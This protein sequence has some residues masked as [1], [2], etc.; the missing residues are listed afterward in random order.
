MG[1]NEFFNA[2]RSQIL[3][4][5]PLPKVT[6]V[7]STVIQ[8]ER[9]YE[10]TAT[11]SDS[12]AFVNL[13]E[14]R[15]YAGRGKSAWGSK[16]CCYCDK[17]GHTV[18]TCYM[19]HGLPPWLKDKSYSSKANKIVAEEDN[20][21]FDDLNDK[22][23]AAEK[24][25]I[26]K[27][28]NEE[29]RTL[30]TLLQKSGFQKKESQLDHNVNQVCSSS[31]IHTG[32]NSYVFSSSINHKVEWIFDCG[33]TDHICSC[34]NEFDSFNRINP[35]SVRLPNGSTLLT[36]LSGDVRISNSLLLKDVLYIPNFSCNLISI[37]K[38]NKAKIT[39]TFAD[40]GCSI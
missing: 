11:S 13:A 39:C 10:V 37:S 19:K 20:D 38:L 18:E 2:V 30:L 8:H 31:A 1:F 29:C 23:V 35:I 34:L 27:L 25:S 6:R 7:F 28:S 32:G 33:A 3:L 14:G 21:R 26:P 22:P 17:T 16:Q 40:E 24:H 4:M 12:H 15:K 36:E 9:Q 5:D